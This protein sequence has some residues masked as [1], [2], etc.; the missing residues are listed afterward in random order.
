VDCQHQGSGLKLFKATG[1]G[2]ESFTAI[3]FNM[4]LRMAYSRVLGFVHLWVIHE[5]PSLS[6]CDQ[7]FSCSRPGASWEPAHALA[8]A[9]WE[10]GAGVR[11]WAMLDLMG[12]VMA[13]VNL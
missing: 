8:P 4:S 6:A 11:V 5:S 3:G 2:I 13:G 12:K 9:V 10:G 7:L 1:L